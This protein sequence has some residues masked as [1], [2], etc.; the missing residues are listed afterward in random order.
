MTTLPRQFRKSKSHNLTIYSSPHLPT[1]QHTGSAHNYP[2]DDDTPASNLHRAK[3]TTFAEVLEVF[4]MNNSSKHKLWEPDP[5]GS[6]NSCKLHTSSYSANSTSNIARIFLRLILIRSIMSSHF[7]RHCSSWFWICHPGSHWTPM[8]FRFD[9]FIEELKANFWNPWSSQWS[10]SQ[11][12]RTL[13][14]WKAPGYKVLYQIPAASHIIW[15][16]RCST[17]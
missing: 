5:F 10:R 9:L 11:T 8:A 14:A 17:L 4:K 2:A 16:G 6:S 7:W 1:C 3:A 12:Q 13:H 15:V